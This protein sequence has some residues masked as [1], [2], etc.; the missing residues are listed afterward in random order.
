M[1]LKKELSVH[2]FIKNLELS[3]DLLWCK[4]RNGFLLLQP[5]VYANRVESW[6]TGVKYKS[7]CHGPKRDTSHVL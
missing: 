5:L 3:A 1:K 4:R 7:M 6:E 2:N